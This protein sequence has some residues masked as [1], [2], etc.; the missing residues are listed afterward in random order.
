[1][2][3][4]IGVRKFIS[5][6]KFTVGDSDWAIRAWFGVRL[7]GK[8]QKTTWRIAT[9]RM[10]RARGGA[11]R[12]SLVS[13]W[14]RFLERTVLDD[15]S[16]DLLWNNRLSIECCV[17]VLGK[18]LV[19]SAIPMSP[20]PSSSSLSSAAL[21]NSSSSDE[22]SR[23]FGKPLESKDRA[24]V[25]FLVKG[26]EF[27]A[28]KAVLAVRWPL[29]INGGGGGGVG[30]N[31]KN[32]MLRHVLAA[33]DRY[34]ME[35]LKDI[36]EMELCRTVSAE[37]LSA[38]F[39]LADQHHCNKLKEHCFRFMSAMGDEVM[40]TSEYNQLKRSSPALLVELLESAHKFPK[41]I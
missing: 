3:R 28:H 13:G 34:G 40:A 10:F 18:P 14:D 9:T 30:S 32:E 38:T 39:T 16:H 29:I 4:A 7:L 5:S 35:K 31:D 2:N 24:D 17:Y 23:D 6:G 20:P 25:V 33:A 27:A 26:E 12:R 8:T 41:Y 22:L 36:C 37:T 11:D 21:T 15:A 19:S 1:M